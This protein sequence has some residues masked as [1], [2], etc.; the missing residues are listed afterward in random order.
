[1][2]KV[3]V[4]HWGA[5]PKRGIETKSL[6]ILSAILFF[7]GFAGGAVFPR[8]LQRSGS[9]E[10]EAREV[11]FQEEMPESSTLAPSQ[12]TGVKDQPP[13]RA[14]F[15]AERAVETVRKLAVDIGIRVEGT[16]A[17]R[18]AAEMLR[19]MLYDY[20]LTDVSIQRFT[21]P[22]GEESCNVIAEVKG[23]SPE[24][25]VVVGAHYD[26]RHTTPGANDNAS[27]AACVVELARVFSNNG[28]AYPTLRFILFGAEEDPGDETSHV[29][30]HFGSRYYVNALTASE[31][32]RIIGMISL[33]MV[34]YGDALFAR[35]MGIGPMRLV[36]MFEDLG[37]PTKKGGNLSDHEPFEKAGVPSVWLEYIPKDHDYD[38]EVHKPG[39]NFQHVKI[40]CLGNTGNL[41]QR[42]LES[43]NAASCSELRSA[44]AR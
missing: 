40:S 9:G 43:L 33:D 32:N 6:L 20:G 15:D 4:D 16:E 25:V 31:L 22:S 39:D 21:L 13:V 27:G 23:A 1:M 38:P 26:S 28:G 29:N 3:E 17:E 12:D 41:V 35:Y 19:G 37:L 18:R 24:D 34:G 8:I 5:G 2:K 14:Q 11:L 44:K 10:A 7:L 42:Y 36:K 30:C